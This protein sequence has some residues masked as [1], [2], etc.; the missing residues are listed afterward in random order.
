MLKVAQKTLSIFAFEGKDRQGHP[1][2]SLTKPPFGGLFGA[3]RLAKTKGGPHMPLTDL[4]IK[5][6]KAKQ[7]AYKVFDGG[8]LYL[9]VTKAGS[10]I[11]KLKYRIKGA[12]KKLTIGPYPLIT[13]TKAR[14]AALDAKDKIL[15]GGDPS[16]EKRL[17]A[18]VGTTFREV[19]LDWLARKEKGWADSHTRTIKSRLEIYAF[20]NIGAL[21]IKDITPPEILSFLRLIEKQGKIETAT[22]T[23]GICSLV[24]RYGVACGVCQSDPCRDLK[25]ALTPY[26][27]KPMA[28][29]TNPDDVSALLKSI[30]DYNGSVVT[31]YALLWSAY[32]FCR[33][34]EIRRAEWR[35]I[36]TKKDEWIIP[37]EKTKPRREHIVPL[38]AQCLEILEKLREQKLSE[39]WIF[40]GPRPSRPLSENGV[41]SALRRMGYAKDEMTAHGFRTIASTFL[42]EAG[43]FRGDVIERQLNHVSKNK[44]RATYNRAEYM[45]ERRKMMQAWADF[46]DNLARA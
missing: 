11:W 32:T 4:K 17:A 21:G 10:K 24:F 42:N 28:A 8:G 16:K 6:L 23:L 5:A 14:R 40:P 13:I 15:Q 7:A 37:P 44:V 19:A 9:E 38:S 39:Q 1:K 30:L 2:I 43:D 20:P 31:K 45:P 36:N 46:L 12:E 18:L 25:G 41:L 34:G 26:Q 3:A 29:L 35:E 27:E 33:P 22:R